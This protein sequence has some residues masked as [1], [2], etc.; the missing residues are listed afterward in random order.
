[1]LSAVSIELSRHDWGSLRT[2]HG[3]ADGV[4]AAVAALVAATTEAEAEHIYSETSLDNVVVVQGNL[5]EAAVPLV[6]VLCA[7]LADEMPVAAHSEVLRLIAEIVRGDTHC[8][9]IEAGRPD[10]PEQAQE[11]ARAGLWLFYR[12]L[13]HGSAANAEYAEEILDYV[14]TD[15]ARYELFLAQ[16]RPK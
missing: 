11:L 12:E 10:L 3:T 7:A 15:R 16:A 2:V 6:S 14:E 8:S 13:L 1:M 4:P 5:F 9:E